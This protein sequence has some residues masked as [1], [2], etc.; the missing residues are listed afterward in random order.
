VI[1]ATLSGGRIVGWKYKV[2]GSAVL[3]RWL[4]AR[5]R[6]TLVLRAPST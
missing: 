1:T 4:P 2:A 3:A 6:G 5:P